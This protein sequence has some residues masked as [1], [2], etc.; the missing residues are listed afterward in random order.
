MLATQ[1]RLRSL[2][3]PIAAVGVL[4]DAAAHAATVQILEPSE[5][6]NIWVVTISGIDPSSG[7][8]NGVFNVPGTSETVSF[9]Y[10]TNAGALTTGT[11]TG[12]LV[13]PDTGAISDTLI[14]TLTAGSPVIGISVASDPF[15]L[16]GGTTLVENGTYQLL[17]QYGLADGSTDYVYLQSDLDVPEPATWAMLLFGFAGIGF[18]SRRARTARAPLSV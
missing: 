15:A 13:E 3:L 7:F 14:A 16:G 5:G 18:A 8:T 12:S 9:A 6:N 10:G 4:A 11:V 2:I 17:A 1:S